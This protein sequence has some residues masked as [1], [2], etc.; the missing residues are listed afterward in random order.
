MEE[1]KRNKRKLAEILL[2][3]PDF[4]KVMVEWYCPDKC[5][6][7]KQC[8]EEKDCIKGDSFTVEDIL[9]WMDDNGV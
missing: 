3:L 5:R 6:Y 8:D 2:S 1:R 7:K 4:K 9:E